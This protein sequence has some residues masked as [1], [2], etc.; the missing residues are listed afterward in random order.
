MQ[1]IFPDLRNPFR[2]LMATFEGFRAL[3]HRLQLL[4][5]LSG[6]NLTPAQFDAMRAVGLWPPHSAGS[7]AEDWQTLLLMRC[8]VR[9]MFRRWRPSS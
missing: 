2:E 6:S 4:T 1:D 9:E 7:L 5:N 3:E 8:R